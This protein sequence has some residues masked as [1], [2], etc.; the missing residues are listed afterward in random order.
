MTVP[1]D[2]FTPAEARAALRSAIGEI[3]AVEGRLARDRAEQL[4]ALYGCSART[5]YRLA[6]VDIATAIPAEPPSGIRDS[7][8]SKACA[9]KTGTE[10][11]GA[12]R[13]GTDDPQDTA[14]PSQAIETGESEPSQ[15]A[16]PAG[17]V[18]KLFG[19]GGV[20]GGDELSGGNEEGEERADE[21][22]TF[23]HHLVAY[24]T[25]G[26]VIDDLFLDL[27]YLCKGNMSWLRREVMSFGLPMPS[28]PTLSR[29]WK[30]VP[31]LV[32]S[33][34]KRG[35]LDRSKH[36][37]YIRHT[38]TQPN[39]AWEVDELVCDIDVRGPDGEPL[40]PRLVLFIDDYSRF[41]T[42]FCVLGGAVTTEDFLCSLSEG[43]ALRAAEDG[44]GIEIGG[45]PDT[46]VFDNA[47][48]FRSFAV[49]D[50]LATLPVSARPSPAYTPTAK[51][52]VER[53]NRTIQD[54][55]TTAMPGI[56]STAGRPDT[57]D[58]QGLA[59]AYLTEFDTFV[60]QVEAAVHAYNYDHVHSAIGV[61]PITRYA[62]SGAA[63]RVVEDT[64]LAALWL[65]AKRANGVRE[66]HPDGVHLSRPVNHKRFYLAEELA[67]LIGEQVELRVQ[68]HRN[69]RVAVFLPAS[70]DASISPG[71]TGPVSPVGRFVCF[72]KE[73]LTAEDRAAIVTT[74]KDQTDAVNAHHHAAR[75]AL[76]ERSAAISLGADLGIEGG[77][78]AAML[79]A[80]GLAVPGPTRTE[81]AE[82]DTAVTAT[83]DLAPGEPGEPAVTAQPEARST[84]RP[85]RR[86][87]T[88]RSSKSP[89]GTSSPATR[90][91]GTSSPASPLEVA[92]SALGATRPGTTK[93]VAKNAA[94]KKVMADRS[95]TGTGEV[96][97]RV[98]PR[99]T[100]RKAK[101]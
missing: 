43:I 93:N 80:K 54:L 35:L 46:L 71:P 24:G 9:Q 32:R 92:K 42:S 26:F 23:L 65:V 47:Q 8:P 79:I 66:V 74:R 30:K 31:P 27:L 7:D 36:L 25:A 75:T 10:G 53:V 6:K 16:D 14:D 11:P 2:P 51:G 82:V 45:A 63:A 48:A 44:S 33:G 12:D 69:D 85:G 55:V 101:P 99:S 68:H 61:T 37:L 39:E 70:P 90:K 40:R 84:K 3:I 50:C 28:L 5:I 13:S 88:R 17:S 15:V 21:E 81:H 4:A 34:A 58:F 76:R 64:Q 89:P 22:I 78:L 57:T 52:K 59:D 29:L 56:C 86:P 94:K 100:V 62:A 98:T 20:A 95:G 83:G 38:A 18:A 19:G 72:A 49:A 73:V 60:D 91:A 96:T 1:L 97:E 67:Q 41:I 77:G 87:A